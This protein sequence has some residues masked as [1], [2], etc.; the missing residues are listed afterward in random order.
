MNSVVVLIL[1]F[2]VFFIGYRFY[3]KTIDTKVIKADPKRA[4]PATM[5]MDGVEFMPTNRKH[6][7]WLPV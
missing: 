3:A 7:V 2:L 6:S 4:T 1:A 5:Y